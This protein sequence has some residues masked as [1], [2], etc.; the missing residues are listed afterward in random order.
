[1]LDF[2]GFDVVCGLAALEGILPT[3][4]AGVEVGGA[5][6]LAVGVVQQAAPGVEALPLIVGH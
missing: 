6:G 1:L 4:P 2:S 3:G 5:A